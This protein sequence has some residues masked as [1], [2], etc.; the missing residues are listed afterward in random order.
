MVNKSII[1]I[2]RRALE[3][4]DSLRLK[5]FDVST[6]A[7]RAQERQRRVLLTGLAAGLAKGVTLLTLVI[8]VPLTIGYLGVERYGLWMTI[9]SVIAILGFA[10]LGMGNGLLNCLSEAHG[11]DDVDLAREY[12]SSAAYLLAAVAAILALVFV[13][14]YQLVPWPRVFNVTSPAAVVEAGP[15]MAVFVACFLVNIPLGIVQR[16]QM[17][18]QE[19]FA[20]SLWQAVGNIIGLV[21]V[22][23]VIHY[24]GSLPW[25]VLAIAGAPVLA[26]LMNGFVLFGFKRPTLRPRRRNVSAPAAQRIFRL[27]ILFFILQIAVALAYSSDNIVIAQILGPQAVSEYSVATRLFIITPMILGMFLAP[28]WP[29][30]G[31][32]ITRGDIQWVKNTL[33]RSLGLSLLVTGL[34]SIILVVFGAQIVKLWVGSA[35]ISPTPPLLLGM[36]IW[37]VMSA[38]GSAIAMFL[39]GSSRIG[40][41]VVTASLMAAAAIGAKIVLAQQIG[42]PGVVWGTIIAYSILTVLPMAVYVPRLIANISMAPQKAST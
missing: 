31:E 7:G 17:G 25:L 13:V 40:F 2:R 39:N 36:G 9:S 41:Q 24:E 27:G 23:A 34:P 33:T 15:A 35:I 22:L 30:Y 28:L 26:T 29:A 10:D 14:T 18:Y 3:A 4:V 12:V 21:G 1:H 38:A 32:S 8:S 11:K 37:T 6:P 16:I 20:N 5:P 19:G 42:L